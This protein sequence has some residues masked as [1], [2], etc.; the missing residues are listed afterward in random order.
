MIAN[1]MFRC[2]M[3]N[4]KEHFVSHLFR[5]VNSI[6]RSEFNELINKEKDAKKR[7]A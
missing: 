3:T 6:F 2:Y 1:E 4:M 5:Y 7:K